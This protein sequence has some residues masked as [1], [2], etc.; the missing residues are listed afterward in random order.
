MLES[1]IIQLIAQG[2]NA[3]VEFK[4]ANVHPDSIAK[5]IVAFAN[6]T[7]GTLLIGVNDNGVVSGIDS[8]RNYEEWSMNIA[9]NNCIPPVQIYFT[10][11]LINNKTIA[12]LEIPKGKDKPYQTND[13]KFLIRVGTTNRTA[14]ANELM[15]LFQQSGFFHFDLTTIENSSIRNLNQQKLAIY[16]ESY[17]LDFEMLSDDEKL[18]LL[19]NTD[20]ISDQGLVTV[21]GMLNFGINPQ[22]FLQNASVSFAHFAQ[23]EISSNLIDKQNI[24]GNLDYIIDTS[25]AIIKNNIQ[26]SSVIEGNLRIEKGIYPEKV[27]RELVVNACCHRNYSILGSKIRIFLFANRLEIISPGRLPNTVTIDKLKA[28][29][30][31]SVNP[32]I[33]KFMENMNYI[34]KL[35]R[36]LPMVCFEAAKIGKQVIFEE[37]GEEF[38][39]TLYL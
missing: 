2:E 12:V 13:S 28:G 18:Q 3:N 23:T 22:R 33:V 10:K 21:A 19:K 17:K 25:T 29:V 27:F 14:S 39:V 1:N 32:V 7:G 37:I 11:F 38:K 9:H 16:F 36:G 6:A 34:D 5:E 8:E 30:S 24:E 31:Y 26:R 15:R 4:S 35:G 20:I